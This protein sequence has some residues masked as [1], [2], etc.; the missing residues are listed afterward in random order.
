MKL[1][2]TKIKRIKIED[3]LEDDGF[4][5]ATMRE[6][7]EMV[8]DI[9]IALWTISTRGNINAQSRLQRHVTVFKRTGS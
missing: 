2:K 5:D 3:N 8:W 4:V 7:V 6:R 9:T 1:D